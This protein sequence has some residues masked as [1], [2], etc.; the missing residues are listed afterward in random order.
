MNGSVDA[1]VPV[2]SAQ[3]LGKEYGARTAVRLAAG[4]MQKAGMLRSDTDLAE[5]VKRSFIDLEG[6]SDE[7]LQMLEVEKIAGAQV[8]PAWLRLQY[9]RYAA[10]P[11]PTDVF[12]GLCIQPAI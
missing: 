6:V 11:N 8:T 12:C 2:L 4:E 1:G 7:W 3:R 5:L 9:A 10:Q